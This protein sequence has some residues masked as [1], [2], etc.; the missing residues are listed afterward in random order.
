M[1]WSLKPE[2]CCRCSKKLHNKDW[3]DHREALGETCLLRGTKMLLVYVKTSIMKFYINCRA[4][5][6]GFQ[7]NYVSLSKRSIQAAA[8]MLSDW[9]Q[10][11]LGE[12]INICLTWKL[13]QN[14]IGLSQ[15]WLRMG[16]LCFE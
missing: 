12:S 11:R 13:L 15:N 1:A 6:K 3:I 10:T 14:L 16:T 7:I 8:I 2:S 5:P 9:G 4:N